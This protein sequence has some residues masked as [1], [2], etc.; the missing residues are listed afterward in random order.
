MFFLRFGTQTWYTRG[1]EEMAK[2]PGL[3]RRG[4]RYHLRLRVPQ[5]LIEHYQKKEI[6]E[7][8][9]TSDFS[10]ARKRLLKRRGQLEEEFDQIRFLLEEANKNADMLS[11]YSDYQLRDIAREWFIENQRKLSRTEKNET[12]FNITHQDYVHE[13]ENYKTIY[14]NEVDG[15]RNDSEPH[16][17]ETQTMRFLA[18]KNITYNH[19]SENFEKLGH[20]LS[21]ALLEST[22]RELRKAKHQPVRVIDTLFNVQTVETGNFDTKHMTVKE[23]CEEYL[24][25]PEAN[26][27]QV[28]IEGYRIVQRVLFQFLGKDRFISEVSR[29]DCRKIKALIL[30]MPTNA[31]KRY[32]NKS[33]EEAI[34]LGKQD[35]APTLASKTANNYINYMSAIFNYALDE[36]YINTNPAR[37]LGLKDQNEKEKHNPFSI[38]ELNIIFHAPLYTGCVDDK[39]NYYKKGNNHP[40]GTRF[41]IPLI[42]LFSGMRLNEICQLYLSDIITVDNVICFSVNHD[43]PDKKVKTSGSV[44]KVPI[45]KELIRMGFLEF[46]DEQKKGNNKRLFPELKYTEKAGYGDAFSKWYSRFLKKTGVKN[47]KNAFHSFRHTFRHV[48]R[49]LECNEETLEAVGGWATGP[50]TH[51]KYGGEYPIDLLD[52]Y[53]Q[54][55]EYEGLDLS[56]LYK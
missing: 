35:N 50:Q 27:T 30:K 37:K 40:R 28:T 10:T 8:L 33:I 22:Q 49:K 41:W 9:D 23:L 19:Q 14:T 25:N 20:L 3:Q 6:K 24:N 5:D 1:M 36:E 4:E 11:T 51:K 47:E 48:L 55:V 13:L 38:E 39:S 12:A 15:V 31:T 53:V 7:A 18:R 42:S 2:I 45:H 34:E 52:K 56:H 17:G 46:V 44:R 29:S 26:R 43:G 32:P 54:Q 16:H 21:R